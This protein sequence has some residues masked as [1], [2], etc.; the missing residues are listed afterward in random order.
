VLRYHIS[1]HMYLWMCL[2]DIT[3]NN[4]KLTH[5]HTH[6]HT[7]TVHGCICVSQTQQ[8]IKHVINTQIYKFTVHTTTNILQKQFYKYTHKKFIYRVKGVCM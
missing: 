8:D 1:E 2:S 5:T 3:H 7:H 6:T 4:N